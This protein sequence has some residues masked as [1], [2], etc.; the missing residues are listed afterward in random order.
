MCQRIIASPAGWSKPGSC[1]QAGRSFA[2][3]L[4]V[5]GGLEPQHISEMGN[6]PQ[7]LTAPVL[8]MAAVAFTLVQMRAGSGS[9]FTDVKPVLSVLLR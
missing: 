5:K 8:A 7:L 3:L 1:L 4:L 9:L 2:C 6:W